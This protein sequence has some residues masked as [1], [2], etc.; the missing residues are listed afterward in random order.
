MIAGGMPLASA[1]TT[2]S[3]DK[4]ANRSPRSLPIASEER[5]IHP[6]VEEAVDHQ[7]GSDDPALVLDRTPELVCAL[8]HQSFTPG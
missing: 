1:V 3:G 6:M 4:S 7:E 2:N 5:W 8:A